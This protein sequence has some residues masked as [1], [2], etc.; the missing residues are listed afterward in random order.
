MAV[1]KQK[2][3][4]VLIAN[5]SVGD[6]DFLDFLLFNSHISPSLSVLLTHLI[7]AKS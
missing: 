7:W 2:I 3:K 5:A 4:K 6:Q 1:K